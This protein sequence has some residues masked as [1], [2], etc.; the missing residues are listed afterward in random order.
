MYSLFIN[1]ALFCLMMLIICATF[2]AAQLV[3]ERFLLVTVPVVAELYGR[4]RYPDE[5]A[6]RD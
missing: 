2:W 4:L 6:R 3:V 1:V 5:F